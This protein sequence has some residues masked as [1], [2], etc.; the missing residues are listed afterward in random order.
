LKIRRLNETDLARFAVLPRPQR[1]NALRKHKGGFAPYSL[2][3]VRSQLPE[4]MNLVGDLFVASPSPR[5]TKEAVMESVRRKCTSR[6]NE[7]DQNLEATEL[8]YD[9][10]SSECELS[11]ALWIKDTRIGGGESLK[12]WLNQYG[13][14]GGVPT[15]V[16]VDPRGTN[17]LT[18]SARQ[19]V[20]SMQHQGLREVDADL[21]DARLLILQLSRRH[22]ARQLGVYFGEDTSLISYEEVN[23][24]VHETMQDWA[25]VLAERAGEA[26]AG[27]SRTGTGPGTFW[28]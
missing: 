25:F 22:G 7:V 21:G 1:L 4:M 3:P 6:E 28:P 18:A 20:F 16:F 9:F 17:G 14:I 15:A 24:L 23:T 27:G 12:Y 11:R 2:N 8:L 5:A 19:F 26:A 10:F 13:V